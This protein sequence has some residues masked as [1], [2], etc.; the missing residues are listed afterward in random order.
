MK[1]ID[2]EPKW[3]VL[4]EGGPRTGLTFQCPHCRQVRLGVAFHPHGVA[5]IAEHEPDA[6]QPTGPIWTIAGDQDCHSFEN[7]TLTP[8]VDAS[9]FG[10]WHGFITNGECA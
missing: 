9:K 2:L 5:A 4:H 8:S 1:L 10:H 7:V 6:H 3:Y